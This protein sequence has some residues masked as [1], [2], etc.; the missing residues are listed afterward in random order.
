MRKKEVVQMKHRIVIIKVTDAANFK[1][2]LISR[3]SLIKINSLRTPGVT[4]SSLSFLVYL[5][6]F[7][8]VFYRLWKAVYRIPII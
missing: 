3:P 5:H 8:L 6:F 2:L 1:D 7:S 4:S